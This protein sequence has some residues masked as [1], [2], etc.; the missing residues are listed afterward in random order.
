MDDLPEHLKT[1]SSNYKVVKHNWTSIVQPQI[2]AYNKYKS[3]GARLFLLT[4]QYTDWP[5]ILMAPLAAFLYS[6]SINQKSI[7]TANHGFH[8]S[9]N[10]GPQ[11]AGTIQNLSCSFLQHKQSPIHTVTSFTTNRVNPKVTKPLPGLQ[12]ISRQRNKLVT[13]KFFFPFARNPQ[14]SCLA[15][16]P[17]FPIDRISRFQRGRYARS[18]H[19]SCIYSQTTTNY[20][21]NNITT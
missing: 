12:P 1:T 5:Q 8:A 18:S 9:I 10:N 17:S 15:I 14:A 13:S 6:L 11:H 3:H 20:S 16:S 7:I 2:T 4:T 21:A 19:P